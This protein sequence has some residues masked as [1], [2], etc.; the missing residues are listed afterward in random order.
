MQTT[1]CHLHQPV[2][3]LQV[4]LDLVMQKSPRA[5]Q[6]HLVQ[7]L[8]VHVMV[9]PLPTLAVQAAAVVA[10]EAVRVEFRLTPHVR[11]RGQLLKHLPHQPL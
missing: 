8:V 5:T 4:A 2:Q 10:R 11:W 9:R 3:I 1:P 6:V 7:H